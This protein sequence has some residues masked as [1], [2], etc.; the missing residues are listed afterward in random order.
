MGKSKAPPPPDYTAVAAASERAAEL[1]FQL[2]REQLAWAREQ[3]DRDSTI[4]NRIIDGMLGDQD[5]NSANAARDRAF[6]E[7]YFQPLERSLA[8]DAASYDSPERRAK[9]MG[10]AQAE[11]ATQFDAQR[12]NA[13]R[14]LEAFGIDPSSTRY[15]ALDI[16]VRTAQAAAQAS[17][18]TAASNRVEDNARALRSEAINVGRGYP[19]QITG[20][21]QVAQGAGNTAGGLAGQSTSI[22][23]QT[24]GTAPQYM[25]LGNQ[26]VGQWGNT[27]N[28]SYKNQLARWEANQQASSGFG[29]A[30]G[31]IGGLAGKAFGFNEGGAVPDPREVGAIPEEASPSHGAAI[32]DVPARLNVGEFVIPDDVVSWY[33]EKHMYGLIEKANKEREQ[34]KQA[35]GAIPEMGAV[36]ANEQPVL[37]TA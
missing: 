32:D 1:S 34:A 15:A 6:Y 3:Y 2:G 17:A 14:E 11:V 16:G 33:G 27:L 7:D 24:M 31:L 4:Y 8:E 21:Y 25:G 26:A 10:A 18:G 13:Q 37:Q 23:G 29:T 35:T 22:G 28:T 5:E 36:P 30:L 9:E 19:G 20:A 12:E